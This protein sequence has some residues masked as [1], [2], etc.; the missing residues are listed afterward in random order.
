MDLASGWEQF[1][2]TADFDTV[3]ASYGVLTGIDAEGLDAVS[4][5]PIERALRDATLANPFSPALQIVRQQCAPAAA[6]AEVAADVRRLREFLLRDDRGMSAQFPILVPTEADAAALIASLGYQPLYGRYMVGSVSGSLPFVAIFYDP[7]RK[8]ERQLYFDFLR[9]W[10]ALQREAHGSEFPAYLSGLSEHYLESAENAGNSAAELAATT[11]RLRR[12]EIEPAAAIA[13]LERLALAGSAPAAFELLPLCI[14]SVERDECLGTALDLVRPLAERGLAEGMVVMA[15]AAQRGLDPKA[16]RSSAERWLERAGKRAGVGVALSA[17]AHLSKSLDDQDK[18]DAAVR[19]AI[20]TAARAEHPP[21]QF[22]LAQW[23]KA[24]RVEPRRGETPEQLMQRAAARGYT[25][26]LA[27]LGLQ[28]LRRREFDQAWTLLE[29]AAAQDEPSALGL[30]A[31]AHDHGRVGRSASPARALGLYRR[32]ALAGNA[33][34]MRR[35]GR[36]YMRGELG[37]TKDPQSA[38]AWY[39]SAALFGNSR[40]A[41]DLAELYLAATP[42]MEGRAT[43]GYAVIE[44]LAADGMVSAKLRQASALLLGQGVTADPAAALKMLGG[45]EQQGN[46]EAS[47]RLGQ[48][49]QFGQGGIPIDLTRARAHYQAGANSGHVA[50]IDQFARALYAGRGG[51]RQRREALDWWQRAAAK[52]NTAAANN[53]AWVRC[54]SRDEAIRDPEK[55]SRALSAMKTEERDANLEDTLA[56]CFAARGDYDQAIATQRNAIAKAELDPALDATERAQLATRL[57]SY[58]RREAWFED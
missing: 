12:K 6:A 25:P 11:S 19:D 2:A 27:Q 28:H 21:A 34:A 54:S 57:A 32:A 33:G 43:D 14:I 49:H 51:P 44:R 10:Q 41:I 18:L 7:E 40:A 5:A 26:A 31:L 22:L 13:E 4:C 52:G 46:P 50:S 15:L 9:V 8:L 17:F 24:K 56:A 45:L 20:R 35:L 3:M 53:L 47:F 23:L 42:G 37:L 39:L 55:G 30:L 36:G 48:A 16:R 38:E 58:E 1:L 29:Q